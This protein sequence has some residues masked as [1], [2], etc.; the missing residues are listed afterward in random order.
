MLDICYEA[1]RGK[2]AVTRS[3]SRTVE[4]SALVISAFAGGTLGYV[5][6][7][8]ALSALVG[9]AVWLLIQ[10]LARCFVVRQ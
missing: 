2:G 4:R 8:V 7:S 1:K 6:D 5:R 9:V 10:G 3:V